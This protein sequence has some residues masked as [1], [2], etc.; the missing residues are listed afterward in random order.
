MFHRIG[1]WVDMHRR[2]QGISSVYRWC[3]VLAA[4]VPSRG[5]W[6]T[7]TNS[8]WQPKKAKGQKLRSDKNFLFSQNLLVLE[9]NNLDF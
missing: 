7:S 4:Q 5:P 2:S 9:R 8:L 3:V 6:G 1:F